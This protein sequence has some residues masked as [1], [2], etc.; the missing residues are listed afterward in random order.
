M[1]QMNTFCL[2]VLDLDLLSFGTFVG[3][4]TVAAASQFYPRARHL[5]NCSKNSHGLR[6]H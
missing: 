1:L 5:S 4:I 3:K 6:A 2:L